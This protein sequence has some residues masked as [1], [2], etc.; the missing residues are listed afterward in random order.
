MSSLRSVSLQ[1]MVNQSQD[2]MVN[3]SVTTFERYERRGTMSNAA[4]YVAIAAVIAGVLGLL[5][6][7]GGLLSGLIG[8]LINFFVFTGL[9]F[10][11][12]R[13]MANG[14]GTWDEVAYTFA[15]FVAPLAVLGAIISAIV[16]LLGWIPFLGA[17]IGLLGL[18]IG[19]AILVGQ[20]YYA[21][22]A[23]QSSM[24][25]SDPSKALTVLGVSVVGTFL[26]QL[27]LSFIF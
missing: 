10:Y 21:Y 1:E 6:G 4:I 19:L 22:L 18:L 26:I 9:V 27:V 15:L 11:L 8:T 5:G 20:A 13:Q 17:L 23:V 25:I 7:F 24:N 3:P 12:G 2:I 14:T 16:F